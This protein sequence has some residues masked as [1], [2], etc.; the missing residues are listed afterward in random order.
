MINLRAISEQALATTL[1]GVWGADVVLIGPDG[2]KQNLRGQVVH[3]V[4]E[5]NPATGATIRVLKS[6]LTL[7]RSS[8]SPV[9]IDGEAWAA[10][11]PLDPT[12]DSATQSMSWD[13]ARKG[14]RTI[15]M[16]T[17]YLTAT[18]TL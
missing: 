10:T 8:L 5:T 7:R 14:S 9:P 1:E 4:V 11:V 17:M 18:G 15:G 3:E 13:Q 16:I 12:T 2:V 6:A